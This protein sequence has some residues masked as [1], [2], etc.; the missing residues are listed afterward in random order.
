MLKMNEYDYT[1]MLMELELN[2]AKDKA[3][4]KRVNHLNKKRKII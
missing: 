1:K 2:D 3:S 4:R